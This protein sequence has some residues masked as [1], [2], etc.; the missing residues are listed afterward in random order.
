MPCSH[1]EPV[2]G[3]RRELK[4]LGQVAALHDERVVATGLERDA[5]PF[6]DHRSSFPPPTRVSG[7]NAGITAAA[8]AFVS[9]SSV[10]G[11][12]S[13]TTP[14]PAWTLAIP[15][16][17][18]AVRIVMQKS[19]SPANVRYPTAP[20]YGPRAVGSCSAIS[21]IARRLGAPVTVPAGNATA[22]ASSGSMSNRRSPSTVDTMCITFE[23]R[24]TTISSVGSTE[25]GAQTRPRSFR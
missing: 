5:D 24:S 23:K 16:T 12:E 14:A 11:S 22:R 15:L 13:A 9:R 7:A 1:H 19:R 20:A 18:E 25:P 4:L 8:L 6:E 17:T 10:W 2:L 3:P 21:S